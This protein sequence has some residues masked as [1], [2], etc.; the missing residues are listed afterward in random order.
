MKSLRTSGYVALMALS[1]SEVTRSTSS[2]DLPAQ[3]RLDAFERLGTGGLAHDQAP[4]LVAHEGRDRGQQ[5][6]DEDGGDGVG[7]GPAEDLQEHQRG[8]CDQQTRDGGEVLQQNREQGCVLGG[9]QRRQPAALS[10]A[11]LELAHRLVGGE[12]LER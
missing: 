9:T 3:D 5:Q 12:A 7:L 4:D 8:E 10:A 6:S 11:G 1:S 2:A